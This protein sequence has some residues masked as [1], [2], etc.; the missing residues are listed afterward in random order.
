MS[1][2][3]GFPGVGLMSPSNCFGP[4]IDS[5]TVNTIN[6]AGTLTTKDMTVTGVISSGTIIETLI[7]QA[8]IFEEFTSGAG[9][10]INSPMYLG[11]SG[12]QSRHTVYDVSGSS[13]TGFVNIVGSST[14]YDSA[15]RYTNTA[16]GAF[17]FEASAIPYMTLYN[18]AGTGK[19]LIDK[20]APNATTNVNIANI[21][22]GPN[23]TNTPGSI[24]YNAN[25]IEVCNNLGVWGP[26]GGGGTVYTGG[27]NIDVTGSVISLIASP[28]VTSV[29]TSGGVSVGG[30]LSVTGMSTMMGQVN[31]NGGLVANAIT[32]SGNISAPTMSTT[33]TVMVGGILTGSAGIS[34][35]TM[36]ASGL[37]SGGSLAVTNNG[38]IDG[39]LTVTG[40]INANGGITVA[41][42][43]TT[44]A[45]TAGTALGGNTLAIT[46][47]GTV[48][49]TLGVTGNL[50]T[51]ATLTCQSIASTNFSISAAGNISAKSLSMTAVSSTS[52]IIAQLATMGA[53]TSLTL[54]MGRD[55][56]TNNTSII[57]YN[58]AGAGF[59]TN[60]L[61]LGLAGSEDTM[62]ITGNGFVGIRNNAPASALDVTGQIRGTNAIIPTFLGDMTF[63][64]N[65]NVPSNTTY[66]FF[67]ATPGNQ[68]GG[69]TINPWNDGRCII[70][71]VGTGN[72]D[73]RSRINSTDAT[74]FM[75]VNNSGVTH[76]YMNIS[77]TLSPTPTLGSF[78]SDIAGYMRYYTGSAWKFLTPMNM[79]TNRAEMNGITSN[80]GTFNMVWPNAANL[81]ICPNNAT[82][83]ALTITADYTTGPTFSQI[84]S[85]TR[86]FFWRHTIDNNPQFTMTMSNLSGMILDF[87]AVGSNT[88]ASPGGGHLRFDSGE[89]AL[90]LHDGVGWKKLTAGVVGFIRVQFV[91]GATFGDAITTNVIE[92]PYGVIT[93][94]SSLGFQVGVAHNDINGTYRGS[95][96]IC[97]YP[98]TPRFFS[99]FHDP[100][101]SSANNM[102][103]LIG[104]GSQLFDM[105]GASSNVIVDFSI[106]M[107]SY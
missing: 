71:L 70:T 27:S 14:L 86:A 21:V 35:T 11:R 43:S 83:T 59:V 38:T 82:T 7:I 19:M 23:T 47:N 104:N 97:R 54:N 20:I 95:C 18:D 34:T 58:F 88:V 30:N 79:S 102:V 63:S 41:S 32:S 72:Q 1:S 31:V 49:G 69:I 52:P 24:R 61:S 84:E 45:I 101:S 2:R 55:T 64:Q 90:A 100:A 40:A 17:I 16:A 107:M 25:T 57:R 28:S 56:T 53:G 5:I 37:V 8:N 78:G 103:F 15:L 74:I 66:N 62:S 44:G 65:N 81:S 22:V 106:S 36:A 50:T 89:A 3:Q 4:T 60:R 77:T 87:M 92:G 73:F 13:A 42:I 105:I 96:Q 85:A 80:T 29:T 99:L 26:I 91:T 12:I 46:T 6:V 10:T 93:S 39:S 9:I 94:A 75:Q 98:S 51:N 33:G 67:N 68:N 48:G 76:N